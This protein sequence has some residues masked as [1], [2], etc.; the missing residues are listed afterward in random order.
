MLT[1]Q[2][3]G[4]IKYNALWQ[5]QGL[6]I[7]SSHLTIRPVQM[8]DLESLNQALNAICAERKYVASV[9]GF[10]L[11][12]HRQFLENILRKDFPQMVALVETKLVGWCD[13]IPYPE[14]GF[15]H[16]GRLGIA[17]LPEYRGQGIGYKL[18]SA[19]LD[20]ARRIKLEKVE[21]QVYADNAAAIA[22]YRKFNFVQEGLKKKGRKLDG[23]YQDILLM[24]IDLNP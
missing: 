7:M 20:W 13:I 3:Q 16:V 5:F 21:L 8:S 14:T 11:E 24:A 9:D 15:T 10:S 22:L 17:I 12:E 6:S 2:R 1:A 18:V 23:Q 4:D 19:C